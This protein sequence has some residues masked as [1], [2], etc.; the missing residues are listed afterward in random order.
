MPEIR[1]VENTTSKY[2]HV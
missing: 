1:S 2:I